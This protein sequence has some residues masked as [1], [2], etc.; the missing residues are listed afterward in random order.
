M[1]QIKFDCYCK[2]DNRHINLF[3]TT[4]YLYGDGFPFIVN[5]F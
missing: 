1:K 2:D 5:I 3:L 4:I